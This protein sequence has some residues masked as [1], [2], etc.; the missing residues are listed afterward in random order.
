MERYY[1][2]S[3]DN[4]LIKKEPFEEDEIPEGYVQVEESEYIQYENSFL[5]VPDIPPQ[6]K[7]IEELKEQ[8]AQ[9]DYQAI[10]FAEGYFTE[11]EYAPIK[12]QRQALRD[13]INALEAELN[14]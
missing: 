2:R 4:F 13:Q 8:L 7:Q 14:G 9:S 11:E 12:A 10:K 3:G 6:I 5:I 1:Y